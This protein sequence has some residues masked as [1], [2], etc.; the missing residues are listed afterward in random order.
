M[1]TDRYRK[2]NLMLKIIQIVLALLTIALLVYF[3]G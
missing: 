2:D 1:E 3:N